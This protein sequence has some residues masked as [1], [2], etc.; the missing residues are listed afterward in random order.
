M[1]PAVA[2]YELDASGWRWL[3][4][5]FPDKLVATGASGDERLC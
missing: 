5:L 4:E 1:E 2:K 3:Y